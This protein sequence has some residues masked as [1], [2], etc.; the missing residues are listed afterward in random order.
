MDAEASPPTL[1]KSDFA[2]LDGRVRCPTP[3][4]WG[5]LVMMPTGRH[6]EEGV[7]RFLPY[8][9]CPLCMA[10]FEIEQDLTDREFYLRVSWLRAN[11]DAAGGVAS[12]EPPGEAS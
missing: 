4:C 7:P 2:N 6:D 1:A 3:D 5:D 8:T 11:P 10:S 12:K 9:A